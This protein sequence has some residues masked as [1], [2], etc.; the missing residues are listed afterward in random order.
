MNSVTK[1]GNTFVP[2]KPLSRKDTVEKKIP[3]DGT[4]KMKMLD[5]WAIEEVNAYNNRG[6]PGH[7]GHRWGSNNTP[8]EKYAEPLT[9]NLRGHLESAAKQ[10][11][12]EGRKIRILDVGMYTGG[13]WA[14]FVNQYSDCVEFFGTVL[15]M[16]PVRPEMK[17]HAIISAASQIAEKFE[18]GSFDF[19]VFHDSAYYEELACL[20]ATAK[21]L[22]TGGE[23]VVSSNAHLMPGAALL[24]R[25]CPCY[26]IIPHG[27]I[28]YSNLA[29]HL[30]KTAEP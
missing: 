10:A 9:L 6:K 25:E 23:A 21:L 4:R 27:N 24:K 26:E 20:R 17:A 29:Y 2:V 12:K 11:R 16:E 5:D 7:T 8:L 15:S 13:Q 1:A 18:K 3:L 28:E 22:R 30:R 14:G 19:V